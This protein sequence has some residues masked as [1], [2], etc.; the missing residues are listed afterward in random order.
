M[1]K[2]LAKHFWEKNIYLLEMFKI[3]SLTTLFIILSSS[4]LIEQVE[5]AETE[6]SSN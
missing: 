4:L 6:Q 3:L 5:S 2:Y 1:E